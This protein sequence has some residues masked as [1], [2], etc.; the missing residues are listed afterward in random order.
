MTYPIYL[1]GYMGMKN[2]D[3]NI[4]NLYIQ[5]YCNV[6]FNLKSMDLKNVVHIYQVW[7]FQ[8]L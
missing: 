2:T 1:I 6:M 5:D 8:V 4:V 7:L 3:Q